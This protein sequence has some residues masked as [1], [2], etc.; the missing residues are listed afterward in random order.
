[1][2]ITAPG[3]S[4]SPQTVGVTLTINASTGTE[5]ASAT[6][7]R[8]DTTT[9]GSWKSVYGAD[10]YNFLGATPAQNTT[11]GDAIGNVGSRAVQ[12]VYRSV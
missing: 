6:Y 7:V 4:G 12:F 9:Q 5:S 3:A 8:L 10:G 2:T 11:L 1:V